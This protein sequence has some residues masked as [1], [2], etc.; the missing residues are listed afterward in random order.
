MVGFDGSGVSVDGHYPM[1]QF[2]RDVSR[3][4][5]ARFTFF[6]SGPYLLTH[7]NIGLY[8]APQ[9][10]PAKQSMPMEVSGVLSLPGQSQQDAV[11]YEMEQLRAAHAEGNEIGTHFN[12]HI[13][14]K[15]RGG[16][17]TFTAADW[18]QE[19]TEF[20]KMLD[21][22]NQNNDLQP[23][24]DPGFS[25]ADIRGSRTPCLDGDFRALYPV[26]ARHGYTYD[27]SPTPETT[28]PHQGSPDTGPSNLWVFPL[29]FI[30]VHGTHSSALSMDYN[31]C[32][33]NGN[34]NGIGGASGD[35]LDQL[36]S[37]Q[38]LDSYRAYFESHYTGD[39]APVFLGEHFEMWQHGA[40]TD[41][42][43][44]FL[45]ET[46]TKPEVKC[47]TFAEL[48][49]WLSA[50]PAAQRAEWERT[51]FPHYVDPSPPRYGR[52]VPGAPEPHAVDSVPPVR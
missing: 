8:N 31:F 6:L 16:D 2:W 37:Q 30:N 35:L 20:N 12:G 32:V 51:Q 42:L 46:C 17:A 9:L 24:V 50:T 13:C 4:A 34:C 3:S 22:A 36:H 7:Q 28:W 49:T 26:L 27:T 52:P 29:A 45:T 43:A 39:R 41:A 18:E 5:D 15:Q 40:Y 21:R 33:R 1:F 19:I 25:S 44:A 10:G 38:N 48:A 23:P 47:V 14:G 11:R